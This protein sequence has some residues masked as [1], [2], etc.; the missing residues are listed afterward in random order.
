MEA[1]LQPESVATVVSRR[2]KFTGAMPPGSEVPA[3][4]EQSELAG[5]QDQAK[6]RAQAQAAEAQAQAAEAEAQ[7]QGAEAPEPAQKTPKEIMIEMDGQIDA[8]GGLLEKI[9][10]FLP[11]PV[12]LVKP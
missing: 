1:D 11:P 4:Y 3:D 9:R 8:I 5:A 2:I 6:A 10:E 7:A 12:A